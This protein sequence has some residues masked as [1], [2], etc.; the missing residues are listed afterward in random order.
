LIAIV[1]SDDGDFQVVQFSHFSVKEYLTSDRLTRSGGDVSQYHI[2]LGFAHTILAQ[3]C[4][5][6]LKLLSLDYRVNSINAGDIPLAR[7]GAEHWVDHA[8]FEIVTT[9]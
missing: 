3:A 5:G 1:D 9:V 6:I 4:P 2:L 7:Y 8:R